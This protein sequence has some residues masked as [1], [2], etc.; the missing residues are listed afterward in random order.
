MSLV[1][2]SELNG[3]AGNRDYFQKSR[4]AEDLVLKCVSRLIQRPIAGTSSKGRHS[5]DFT[6]SQGFL[7]DV[8]IW[9][10]NVVK[11]ELS[12]IRGPIRVAGW[13]QEYE[14]LIN[15]G[16]LLTVNSWHSKY[17]NQGV[18]KIRWIPWHS[19]QQGVASA[20]AISNQRGSYCEL[21]PVKLEHYW[22]GDFMQVA[23]IHGV[24][25]SAFDASR[26]HS[27]NQLNIQ[28]LYK[29]F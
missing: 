29:W 25:H 7:G 17:H 5:C 8:K 18:F 2:I 19:I 12:Q 21:D 23:S 15:F 24:C 4:Q 20:K 13:Y 14:K 27:N 22:L 3:A 16:G 1:E 10:G 11:V 26:I 28:S 6:T 9:S